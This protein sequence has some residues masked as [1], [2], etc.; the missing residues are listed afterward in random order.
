MGAIISEIPTPTPPS[1]RARTK[2]QNSVAEAEVIAEIAYNIAAYVSIFFLPIRSLIGPATNIVIVATKVRQATAQPS[3]IFVNSKYGS[4]NLTTPEITE[5]SK[6]IKKPP[7]ATIKA[8]RI[9]YDLF[10]DQI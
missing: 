10:I 5:A 6:P 8:I 7:R 1:I 9:T 2:N 4:I 3:C